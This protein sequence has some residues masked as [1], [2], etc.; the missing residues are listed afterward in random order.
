MPYL[1]NLAAL[2]EYKVYE[3]TKLDDLVEIFIRHGWNLAADFKRAAVSDALVSS[4]KSNV[5]TYVSTYAEH[6]ILSNA[7]GKYLGIAVASEISELGKEYP[8]YDFSKGTEAEKE[9]FL[10]VVEAQ[11]NKKKIGSPFYF[12]MVESLPTTPKGS[13]TLLPWRT[14]FVPPTKSDVSNFLQMALDVEITETNLSGSVS[15][16]SKQESRV[17]QSPIVQALLRAPSLESIKEYIQDTNWWGD[18]E[19]EVTGHIDST[20]AFLVMQADDTPLWE[21]NAVPRIPFYFGEFVPEDEGDDAVVLFAGTVP[22]QDSL[23]KIA[24]YDY[25]DS[26]IQAGKQILPVGK[27]YKSYPGNGVDNII[28]SRSARGAKYQRHYLSVEAPPNAIE[29]KRASADGKRKYPRAIPQSK[30]GYHPSRYSGKVPTTWLNIVHPDGGTR[31]YLKNTIGVTG[32][33][34]GAGEIRILSEEGIEDSKKYDA[35]VVTEVSASSPVTKKP[36]T[37]FRPV[38]IAI[39]KG[40]V[41]S[42][43]DLVNKEVREEEVTITYQVLR[44]HKR[45]SWSGYS[46]DIDVYVDGNQYAQGVTGTT[47]YVIS[48]QLDESKEHK[49]SI[50]ATKTNEL[51]AETTVPSKT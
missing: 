50:Y 11:F 44:K 17:M 29:P 8:N 6:K 19:I 48:N 32:G 30:Y 3:E 27:T 42:R 51:L 46:G 41:D 7:N 10:A 4:N 37:P 15:N 23:Q 31:G 34:M 24:E 12:Y 36:A 26:K 43:G 38:T 40:L 22:D 1:N 39:Y 33:Q 18:S 2:S 13:T 14:A 16:I 47:S 20:G 21:G 5:G 49:I 28:V 25:D 35:Y 45:I 9:A